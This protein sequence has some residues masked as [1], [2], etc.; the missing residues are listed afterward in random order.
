[1]SCCETSQHHCL[2]LLQP[3]ACILVEQL[4]VV[5]V[6]LHLDRRPHWDRQPLSGKHDDSGLPDL[7]LEVGFRASWFDVS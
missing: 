7:D 6:Q 3:E 2:A 4:D 5:C 1:M